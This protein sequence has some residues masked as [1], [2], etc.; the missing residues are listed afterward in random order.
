MHSINEVII[1]L[2]E[3]IASCKA[4]NSRQAYF[5]TLYRHM[6]VA[7]QQSILAGGF[8]DAARM[9]KLDVIF[10][11]RY[12]DAWQAYQKQQ[13]TTLSW[14]HAFGAAAKQHTVMQHL[15]L[16]IN[17]HINLDLSIAAAST[18]PGES[19]FQLQKDFDKINDIIATLSNDIQEKLSNI[20]WPMKWLTRISNGSEK[21]V[22]NFS[23]Q[24]ARQASWANAVA[25]AVENEQQQQHHI[26]QL[27]RTVLLL[28]KKIESP[29]TWA[30]ILL[31]PVRW[32]EYN[33]V[34]KVIKLLS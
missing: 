16:G 7:V 24:K 18:S 20:W 21:A 9:E 25:L 17:T 22:L 6:T 4:A 19:I 3:I 1:A 30:Q 28:G 26:E 33:D 31:A 12:I 2:D 11:K 8:E 23:I 10:A 5:A 15:L 14:S 13:P 27:D 29:G 34:Q 32:F